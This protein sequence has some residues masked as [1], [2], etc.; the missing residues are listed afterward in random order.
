MDYSAVGNEALNA[1]TTGINNTSSGYLTLYANTTGNNNIAEGYQAGLTLTTGS[2]NI[3]IGHMGVAV[4]AGSSDS[5]DIKTP[6]GEFGRL[7][8]A[9]AGAI[10]L[11]ARWPVLTQ[12]RQPLAPALA[13]AVAPA[14]SRSHDCG[15][16]LSPPSLNPPS[17]TR[18]SMPA[19]ASRT[20]SAFGA[21]RSRRTLSRSS[22][23]SGIS[24]K[25][26]RFG[27]GMYAILAV[28][29]RT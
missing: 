16:K 13:R 26:A 18:S 15:S 21:Q 23:K 20:I 11:W 2:N 7:K 24:S 12:T 8:V 19:A 10:C 14:G 27:S 5:L 28:S 17:R 4:E 3:D 9:A 25:P 29:V 6:R 1:N 22:W